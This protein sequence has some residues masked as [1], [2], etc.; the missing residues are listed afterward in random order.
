MAIVA[1]CLPIYIHWHG[2]WHEWPVA[3]PLSPKYARA[4]DDLPKL[5]MPNVKWSMRGKSARIITKFLKK[6][7]KPG[8]FSR[9]IAIDIEDKEALSRMVLETEKLVQ[10]KYDELNA[11]VW[12]AGKS[13]DG[14]ASSA[15]GVDLPD[16]L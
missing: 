14:D 9:P 1:S 6:D 8:R 10:S 12:E 16:E 15:E 5:T 11:P 13:H 3:E 4:S 7:G 2:A